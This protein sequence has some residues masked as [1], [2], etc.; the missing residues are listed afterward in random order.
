MW[1]NTTVLL[2][3]A[4]IFLVTVAAMG[5]GCWP[6]FRGVDS[7]GLATEAMLPAS[8]STTENVVWKTEIP[9][10]GWSSPIVW[11]DK[12]IITSAVADKPVD[13]PRKGLYVQGMRGVMGE[14]V[15]RWMIYCL[16]WETGKILWERMAHQGVP[17]I[18]IHAKNSYA[19]ETPATDGERIVVCFGAVGL[20]C[21]DM[22]GQELWA[23]HW[24][25]LPTRMGWGPANSPILYQ[26]R[27]YVLNDNEVSSFLVALDKR[28]GRQIWRVPRDEKTSW[29]TPLVWRNDLRTEIVTAGSRKLRS[30][31][32]EGR[33][34]WELDGLSSVTIPTPVATKELLFVASGYVTE[35]LRPVYAIRPGA[36]GDITLVGEATSNQYVAW[37]LP[38]AA[39]YNPS[40][41]VYGDYLYV[42][43]DRGSLACYDAGTGKEIYSRQRLSP[44]RASFSASPWACDGKVY[45]LSEDAETFVVQAGKDF[46]VLGRNRQEDTALA[47]PAVARNDLILRVLSKVYRI[48]VSKEGR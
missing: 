47:S 40:P 33:P 39:P 9:G 30:Y 29:S 19:T 23:H 28:T 6:Q 2:A 42:L 20:F 26:D 34:L 4:E 43:Y 11:D 35:S 15:Y 25:G 44:E 27:V 5:Q 41:L 8:W 22:N 10:K 48:G 7:S 12:I 37:S 16:D 21:Y 45:C 18:P 36:S 31:D 24:A 3:A 38:T 32:L 17:P 46:K 14:G 13:A 1:K